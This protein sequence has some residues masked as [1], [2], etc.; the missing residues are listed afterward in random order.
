MWANR[1]WQAGTKVLW[2][3]LYAVVAIVVIVLAGAGDDAEPE[4][5]DAAAVAATPTVGLMQEPVA[6]ERRPFAELPAACQSLFGDPGEGDSPNNWYGVAALCDSRSMTVEEVRAYYANDPAFIEYRARVES[7]AAPE[8]TPYVPPPPQE[9]VAPAPPVATLA[10]LSANLQQ[11]VRLQCLRGR[12]QERERR[13]T[14]RH[15][16]RHLVVG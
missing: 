3:L 15:R 7:E 2:T 8:R 13:N 4:S 5:S 12:R 9:T 6:G 1:R 10:L 11:A 14:V 16:D